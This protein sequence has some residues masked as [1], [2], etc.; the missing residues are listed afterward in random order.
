MAVAHPD[1]GRPPARVAGYWQK[2]RERLLPLL[3]ALP[4]FAYVGNIAFY[5]AADA[6]VL[7]FQTTTHP[8][9]TYNYQF[10]VGLGLYTWIE[11]TLWLTAG[12]LAL[13]FGLALGIASILAREF[14]GKSVFATIAILPVGIAT[15]VAGYAWAVI[16]PADGGGYA[17][18]IIA[19]FGVAPQYWL[20]TTSGALTAVVLADSWKNTALIVIILVAGYASIPKALYESAAIDGAGPLRRFRY[21]TL[22][23]LRS[24][25]VIALLIRGAQE[26]NIFQLAYEMITS[27]PQLL[28]VEIYDLWLAG[29]P[30][31]VN[32]AAS[33]ATVL[34]GLVAIFI[35]AVIFLGGRE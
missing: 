24:F 18:S 12:A 2:N 31:S 34:L 8:V 19:F 16:L 14:R 30:G 22:P 15:V 20:N 27:N 33:A 5:P 25:I 29:G 3:F 7:S 1:E 26:I 13:Q 28:T 17:N 6:I 23:G 32:L 21:V 9:T 35:V 11:N 10:N 4:A